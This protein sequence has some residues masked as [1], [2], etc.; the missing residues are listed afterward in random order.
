[1]EVSKV[2]FLGLAQQ[3]SQTVGLSGL[4]ASQRLTG[5][6]PAKKTNTENFG[7]LFIDPTFVPVASENFRYGLSPM[8]FGALGDKAIN[9]KVGGRLNISA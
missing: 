6:E 2:P 8:G 7:E 1:M 4:N 3:A 5:L 9:G